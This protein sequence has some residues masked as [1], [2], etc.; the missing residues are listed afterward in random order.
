MMAVSREESGAF[1]AH[2]RVGVCVIVLLQTHHHLLAWHVNYSFSNI[3][4][5]P[6]VNGTYSREFQ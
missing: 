6:H 4:R 5:V 2:A 3:S 1:S